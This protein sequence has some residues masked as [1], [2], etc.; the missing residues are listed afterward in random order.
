MDELL[1][2][3]ENSINS[4]NSFPQGA[5]QPI[6]T[7]LKSGGM[8]SMAAFVGISAKS[9]GT[10][11]VELID[12]A[13]KVER[14]LLNTKEITQIAKNGFPTKEISINV[15]EESLLR[16]GITMQEISTAV[17]SKN[18]DITAGLIR[19]GVQEMSIRA[20]DRGTTEEEIE[21]FKNKHS[22]YLFAIHEA[23]FK[24]VLLDF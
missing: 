12:I 22:Q 21:A 5:E 9:K 2:D 11:D 14:D 8:G 3:V 4:I 19:G 6:I 17:S 23:L 16:F 18:I 1:S 15:N 7:R 13:T 24:Q 20:N 10:S